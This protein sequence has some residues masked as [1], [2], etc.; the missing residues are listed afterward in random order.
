MEE[1]ADLEVVLQLFDRHVD[2]TVGLEVGSWGAWGCRGDP[3]SSSWT[4]GF[5]S[6]LLTCRSWWWT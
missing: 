1:A 3:Q 2:D 4:A 6:P 5:G